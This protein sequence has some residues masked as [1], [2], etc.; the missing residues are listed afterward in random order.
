VSDQTVGQPAGALAVA[1]AGV[2]AVVGWFG[3]ISL[4]RGTAAVIAGVGVCMLAM[5]YFISGV[6]MVDLGLVAAAPLVLAAGAALPNNGSH[7][8]RQL[9]IRLMIVLFPLGIA[10]G[11]AVA[12]FQ[13]E[14]AENSA[15]PY[16]EAR[17][18]DVL[19]GP[20]FA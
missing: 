16:S 3:D 18:V 13:R 1:L 7:P 5:A 19:R 14:K 12:Q 6:P 15:D 2:A 9:A 20:V 4:A 17:P 11:L 8:S 10:L